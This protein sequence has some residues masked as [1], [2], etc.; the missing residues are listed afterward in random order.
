MKDDDL[1]N[2]DAFSAEL[3]FALMTEGLRGPR[4]RRLMRRAR[5]DGELERIF[6]VKVSEFR[7]Y[8]KASRAPRLSNL[9]LRIWERFS[10]NVRFTPPKEVVLTLVYVGL[11]MLGI[12]LIKQRRE[13]TIVA[14]HAFASPL[15]FNDF[16]YPLPASTRSASTSEELSRLESWMVEELQQ[17]SQSP[18]WRDAIAKQLAASIEAIDLESL[19]ATRL[20][21]MIDA[22]KFNAR[23]SEE[24]AES[25]LS[26]PLAIAEVETPPPA[27]IEQDALDATIEQSQGEEPEEAGTTDN[28]ATTNPTPSDAEAE[29]TSAKVDNPITTSSA[30]LAQGAADP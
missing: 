17:A 16:A 5:G 10:D 30:I 2:P 3:H 12:E 15:E 19:L 22:P 23:V 8:L 18:Q 13:P 28:S 4:M 1:T 24:V 26:H 20:K 9:P 14:T 11:A 29:F 7:R 25:E 27:A 6:E 21:A